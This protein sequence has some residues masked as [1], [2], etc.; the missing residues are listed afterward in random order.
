MRHLEV[1]NLNLNRDDYSDPNAKLKG[2]S[3]VPEWTI[4]LIAQNVLGS[5]STHKPLASSNL[6]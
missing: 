6:F 3:L 1:I 5:F 2:A 4:V